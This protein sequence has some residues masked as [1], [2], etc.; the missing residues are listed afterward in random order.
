MNYPYSVVSNEKL[1]RKCKSQL[2]DWFLQLELVLIDWARH[3]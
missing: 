3:K 1:T 2:P